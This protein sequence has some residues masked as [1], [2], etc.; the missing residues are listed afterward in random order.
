LPAELHF[1]PGPSCSLPYLYYPSRRSLF[2]SMQYPCSAVP[3]NISYKHETNSH[4]KP[5]SCNVPVYRSRINAT[6]AIIVHIQKIK[7]RSST[8]RRSGRRRSMRSD[9]SPRFR[10]C[11]I[12]ATVRTFP[13]YTDS[14]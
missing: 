3:E 13:S 6:T 10:R 1:C 4:F 8:T 7:T 9:L 14:M 5:A 2:V 12:L 11:F